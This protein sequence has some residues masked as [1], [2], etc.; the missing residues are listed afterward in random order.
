MRLLIISF[1]LFSTHIFA[2]IGTGQ[3]R[4]HVPARQGID[5]AV[6]NGKVYTAFAN[7]VSEYDMSSNEISVWDA[8]NGLS[9]I[10]ISCL[11]TA[12]NGNA[13]FIGYENGNIDKLE[14]NTVTNIPAIRLAEVLGSKKIHSI[15]EHDGYMFFATGFA[16]VKIDPIKNEVKD[17][18]YPTNG[19]YPILDVR[20]KGDSI[21]AL[22]EDRL[23]KGLTSNI[24]LADPTQW[25]VDVR[26]PVLDSN[27]YKEL[28]VDDNELYLLYKSDGYGEDTVYQLTNGGLITTFTESFPDIEIRSIN[29]C[30][31]KLMVNF[32]AA[33]EYNSD[34]SHSLIIAPLPFGTLSANATVCKDGVYWIADNYHGLVRFEPQVSAT[35]ISFSGPPKGSFYSMDWSKDRLLVVGGG[36]SDNIST[37]NSS[38][39]YSFE[40]EEW[41][42]F[43]T[44]TTGEWGIERAWDFLSVSTNPNDKDQIA[45]GSYSW[46]PLSIFDGSMENVDTLTPMNSPLEFSVDLDGGENGRSLV[47]DVKYDDQGNLWVLN[48]S[49]NSPLKVYTADGEWQTFDLGIA[50]KN[51]FSRKLEIDYNGTKWFALRSGGMYGFNDAGT[52]IAT[53]DDKYIH[54]TSG[55]QTGGL[56]S[57]EVTAIAVD[58]DNEIWIG[59]DAGFAVLYNAET[60]IEGTLGEYNAQRIKLEYEGNVEYVLGATS[61]TDIVVDGANRKWFGTANAGIILL[62]AD[63]LE[64]LEQYTTENSPLISNS[65]FDLELDNNTGELYI[66]TDKGLVSYRTDATYGD[67]TYANVKVF[68]NPARPDFDGPI[69][70]QGI[71]YDSDVK[72]TDVAGNVVYQTTSNGG[73]ATWNGK[74]LT[75]DPVKTGVYLIWTAPNDGKGR[76]VGKVLIVN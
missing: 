9:D 3:W 52:P 64:I 33:I 67:P 16:I 43:N 71:Q 11:G 57:N 42:L 54:M 35:K 46:V 55:E 21:Y 40:D 5:V 29:V 50:S 18:Y 39:M 74:T 59:T 47:S 30:N 12:P 38:G 10:T 48:G 62:S 13:V 25:E 76:Q 22:A 28:E 31:E 34:W 73:T 7:G 65:V 1:V 27:A 15:V 19:N 14:N 53:N 72:I 56:P 66:I 37:F 36:V 44:T 63:G 24:A 23:Y 32:G 58:F 68:P 45:V 51:R 49:S 26:V 70:M 20:F 69:T 4:L 8:V 6:T 61:I 41:D 2:Q 75:G 60:A 17:S